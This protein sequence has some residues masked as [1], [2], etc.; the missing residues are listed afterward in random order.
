M[1][2]L[3][4]MRGLPGSSKSTLT[5]HLEKEYDKP[6]CVCSADDYWF[7]GKEKIPENYIFDLN[8]LHIAHKTCKEKFIAA[9]NDKEP[10]IIVDNT[11]IRLKEY[12]FYFTTGIELGYDI[13]FHTIINCSVEDSLQSNIH[14][15]PREAI[16]RMLAAFLPTPK[17]IDGHFTDEVIYDFYEL[18]GLKNGKSNKETKTNREESPNGSEFLG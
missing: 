10:L 15:V 6:A 7:F 14:K 2:N 9:I 5:I 16:E 17:E 12:K 13:T 11:N 4:I 8:K 1:N 3:L 18:R